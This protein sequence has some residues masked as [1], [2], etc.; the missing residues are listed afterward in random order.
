[1]SEIARLVSQ[2]HLIKSKMS[3]PFKQNQTLYRK[4]LTNSIA[5]EHRHT[6]LLTAVASAGSGKTTL[7]A[8]LF[9]ESVTA[10]EQCF[11]LSLDAEDN[12][13]SIFS[14]YFLASCCDVGEE[15]EDI[16]LAFFEANQARDFKKFLEILII[17]LVNTQNQTIIYVDDFQFITNSTIINFWNKLIQYS[18]PLLRIVIGSRNRLPLDLGRRKMSGMIT[19]VGQKDLNLSANEV[20]TYLQEVHDIEIPENAAE[21]LQSLTEGWIAGVQLAALA[22]GQDRANAVSYIESFT[23]KD[24]ILTEYLL[25]TVLKELPQAVREFL[26]DTA[27]LTRFTADL[28]DHIGKNSNSEEMLDHLNQRNLFIVQED[29]DDRWHR[30]HHLF[31]DFLRIEL[32]K[33]NPLKYDQICLEAANWCE[34]NNLL[35]EAVQYYLLAKK[36]NKA[37]DLITKR[38][39]YLAQLNGDHH[40]VLDWIRRL[41]ENYH[42]SSPQ[43]L[44]V[45][46]WSSTFSREPKLAVLLCEKVFAGIK[47]SDL[48]GWKLSKDE[49]L[50]VFWLAKAIEA[51]AA[52]VM[53]ELS[54]S[55]TLC[56]SIIEAAPPSQIFSLATTYTVMAY[57]QFGLKEYQQSITN[58]AEGYIYSIQAGS[59]FAAVWADFISG[60]ANIEL[61][62]LNNALENANRASTNAGAEDVGNA[63]LG[64]MTDFIH[65]EIN[66]QK[67]NFDIVQHRLRFART[68]TLL[69][70]PA[71]P[72]L[73]SI[74]G[75][76][77]HLFWIGEING[78]RSILRNGQDLA[79]RTNQIRLYFALLAEE[80]ELQIRFNNSEAAKETIK[81]V[82]FYAFDHANL[83]PE[84]KPL[85]AETIAIIR[86]RILIADN[87]AAEALKEIDDIIRA[88]EKNGSSRAR[89]LLKI[90]SLKALS[91]WQKDAKREGVRELARV[92]D[93]AAPE[94]HSYEIVMAGSGILE[95]LKE[96]QSN[97][98]TTPVGKG[99]KLK[100][101]FIDRMV[102]FMQ[103]DINEFNRNESRPQI[104]ISKLLTERELDILKLIVP[105]LDNN[106][107]AGEL[108]LSVATVKWHIHN[109]FQKIGV[110]SRTAAA[111]YGH[112]ANL[113]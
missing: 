92:I 97:R 45:H 42:T 87:Q 12:E 95:M 14:M 109:I 64:A 18:T 110:R 67:C 56:K 32:K 47:D 62:R 69:Y 22:I 2:N 19:E 57:A 98:I 91:Y 4:Q 80:I 72:L 101:D 70:G 88:T 46:A 96:M 39:P 43:L 85:I 36:F 68:F 54:R 112:K 76:A 30:Y 26:L 107:I 86:I 61:G 93:L 81:R 50:E 35:T 21:L 82:N 48:Y 7:M 55:I 37:A 58:A 63:Y 20:S 10:G 15:S 113:I 3:P 105:G 78:G 84:F 71:E 89:F 79:L 9:E 11:W 29:G 73:T 6:G 77:R 75:D 52:V 106:Q 99:L 17:Q 13:P 5:K 100:Y 49:K 65:N 59:K 38:G 24:K 66:V 104:D 90:H 8:H 16:E 33:A 1:M 111:A 53:E 44:L 94:N 60:L 41:P 83:P 31:S 27:P 108:Q 34:S 74:R 28:C 40:T 102:F 103:G 51:I 25:Q 23:G